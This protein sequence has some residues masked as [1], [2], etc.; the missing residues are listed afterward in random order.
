M[1]PQRVER[2]EFSNLIPLLGVLGGLALALGTCYIM[3]VH[4]K[5][6][7]AGVQTAVIGMALLLG[8]VAVIM[9][10]VFG[11]VMPKSVWREMTPRELQRRE[12]DE[13]APNE[14]ED[15]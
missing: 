10:A 5:H 14:E 11:G 7:P 2:S 8:G 1:K 4:G 15:K 3:L 6:L 12:R 13:D 9:S